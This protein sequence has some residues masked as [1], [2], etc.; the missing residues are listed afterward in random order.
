MMKTVII[1][2][3]SDLASYDEETYVVDEEF[4]TF[5]YRLFHILRRF[6]DAESLQNRKLILSNASYSNDGVDLVN[7]FFKK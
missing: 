3:L 7:F 1:Q 6:W 5:Y 2:C 4:D